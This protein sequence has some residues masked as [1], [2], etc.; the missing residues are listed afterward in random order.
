MKSAAIFVENCLL[1]L[2]DLVFFDGADGRNT[3]HRTCLRAAGTDE[4][5]ED[6]ALMEQIKQAEE[7]STPFR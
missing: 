3:R 5:E 1:S 6:E 7:K 2:H 4:M